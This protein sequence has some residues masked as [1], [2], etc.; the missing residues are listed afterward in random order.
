MQI[1]C[2]FASF[3]IHALYNRVKQR[4]TRMVL[5]AGSLRFFGV[6]WIVLLHQR[7]VSGRDIHL[8]LFPVILGRFHS[9]IG[10][11]F[12]VKRKT[13]PFIEAAISGIHLSKTFA[14]FK[15]LYIEKLTLNEKRK[16]S[17]VTSRI[18]QELMIK[19]TFQTRNLWPTF[20]VQF[21]MNILQCEGAFSPTPP[22]HPR[23]KIH[24]FHTESSM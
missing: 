2:K 16:V 6:L 17:V 21:T 13:L 4:R 22:T 7:I 10:S 19:R 1:S 15:R 23:L 9:E 5:G 3:N 14:F 11:K 24:F 12:S 20:I 18:L 8:P